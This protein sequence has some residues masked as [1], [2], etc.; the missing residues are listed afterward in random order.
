[1]TAGRDVEPASFQQQTKKIS[2]HGLEMTETQM[3]RKF[4]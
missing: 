1:M 4:P 2:L 3:L